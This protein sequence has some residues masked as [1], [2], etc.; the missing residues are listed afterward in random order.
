ME[1][2]DEAAAAAVRA[3][4]AQ[5]ADKFSAAIF[6]RGAKLELFADG[7]DSAFDEEQEL[8]GKLGELHDVWSLPRTG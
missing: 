3:A 2:V 8:L 6:R 5:K 4:Q 1:F 7:Q